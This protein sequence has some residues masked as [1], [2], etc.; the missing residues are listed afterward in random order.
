[1]AGRAPHLLSMDRLNA[2][3]RWTV[4]EKVEHRT[5][6]QG[7]SWL[8]DLLGVG[9]VLALGDRE[10]LLVQATTAGNFSSRVD[11]IDS[12]ENTPAILAA[13]WRIEIHGWKKIR[14]RWKLARSETR[15]GSPTS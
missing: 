4:V 3:P 7:K 13:G 5:T 14:G 8:T 1:M 15:I 10:T 2:D 6:V 12:H 11:K 9:D